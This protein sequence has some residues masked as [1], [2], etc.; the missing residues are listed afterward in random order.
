[1]RVVASLTTLPK[2]I[3]YI[4]PVIRSLV[5]QSHILDRIYLNIPYIT[6]SGEKYNVPKD[7]LSSY[8]LVHI[9]RC[10]DYGPA[11]KLIPTLYLETDPKTIIITFDDDTIV[12]KDV[13][14]ILLS[15]SRVYPNACLSFSG[16][17]VGSFPFYCQ[18][19][20]DNRT[21]VYADWIQGVHSIMYKRA[22]LNP[23][24]ITKIYLLS[25]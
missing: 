18:V 3:K 8:S 7:F 19:A 1:M 25:R 6:L 23:D 20:L 15:K 16:W 17:C 5:S 12:H 2:R 21:D 4:R 24:E 11:T 14:R 10:I 22:F 9:N 13:V